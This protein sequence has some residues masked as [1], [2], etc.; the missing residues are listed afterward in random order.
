[1]AITKE[2]NMSIETL[3]TR[4]GLTL[5]TR[6][7]GIKVDGDGPRRWEHH[8]WTV[9]L[10]RGNE[11]LESPF[12]QG[13]AHNAEPTLP[14]VIGCMVSDA[15]ACEGTFDEFCDGYGYDTDSRRA[16]AT[17]DACRAISAGMHR[18]LGDDF[19]A[20]ATAVDEAGL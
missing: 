15:R 5:Q 11:Q 2:P 12:R 9:T 8:A 13:L 17:Y 3:C 16:L 4:L 1:M 18:L 6:Y 14:E 7:H 10:S 20:V 19:D